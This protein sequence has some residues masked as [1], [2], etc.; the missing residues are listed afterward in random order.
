MSLRVVLSVAPAPKPPGPRLAICRG[1]LGFF[2]AVKPGRLAVSRKAQQALSLHAWPIGLSPRQ[3]GRPPGC[4]HW[5]VMRREFFE[6]FIM[7]S[8]VLGVGAA[9]AIWLV[10]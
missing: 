5:W 1:R 2:A 4:R 7:T 10:S 8:L 3:P 9:V 6:P